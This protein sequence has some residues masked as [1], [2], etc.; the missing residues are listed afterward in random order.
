MARSRWKFLYFSK[1]M[2]RRSLKSTFLNNYLT[3]FI[4]C[5]DKSS[6]IPKKFRFTNVVLHKGKTFF[7][8]KITK[9]LLGRKLGEFVFTRKPFYCPPKKKKKKVRR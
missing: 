5:T 3:G 9:F 2:F 8:R 6:S 7:H 4:K 1:F